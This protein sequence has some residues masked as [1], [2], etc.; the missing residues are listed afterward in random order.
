VINI[1]LRGATGAA[2][3][4]RI[5]DNYRA[6]PPLRS[7]RNKVRVFQDFGR[8]KFFD[9]DN[10]QSRRKTSTWLRCRTA[11]RLAARGS[12]TEPKMKFNNLF[13]TVRR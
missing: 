9:A 8:E 1:L 2:K 7:A 6:S 4:K 5:L 3:I 12:G 11:T 10:E 13:A